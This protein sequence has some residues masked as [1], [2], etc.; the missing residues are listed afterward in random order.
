MGPQKGPSKSLESVNTLPHMANG[1]CRCDEVRIL[2]WEDYS[3]LH[4][5]VQC[6]NEGA[7]CKE[8]GCRGVTENV[9]TEAEVVLQLLAEGPSQRM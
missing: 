2:R 1:I 6:N 5:W 9:M 3:G 7:G 8:E 4:G